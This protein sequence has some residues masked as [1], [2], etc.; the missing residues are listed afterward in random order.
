MGARNTKRPKR[1]AVIVG[2]VRTPFLRAFGAFTR[3][4]AIALGVAAVRGLLDRFRVPWREIDSLFW[5]GVILPGDA[6]NVGREIVL[7]LGLP[8]S[9][10]AMTVTRACTSSLLSVTLAAAAIERGDAEVIIAGGGDSTSNAEVKMPQSL[11]HKMAPVVMS[12]KSTVVDYFKLLA[13]INPARDLVPRQPSVRERTTGEL[14]GEAAERM[15]ARWGISREAQDAFAVQSHMRAAKAYA[16]GILPAE[17]VPVEAPGGRRILRDD[18]VRGDTSVEK[19]SRLRPAF[20]RDGTL[21]AGNSS[22]LTDGAA[23]LLLMSEEK[24]RALGFR[25]LAAFRSWFYSAV[26]PADQLLIGPA[27]AMPEAV[28]RAGMTLEDVDLIDIHEAFA[29]QVLCVLKAM[30]SDRFCREWAGM[31]RA[32]GAIRPE[33][34]NVHGGSVAL[35][36]PFAATGGRMLITMANELVRSGRATALLGLCAAGGQAGAAVLEA[37]A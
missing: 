8:R 25:P 24:A 6:P 33:D 12:S 4:D 32:F 15:A 2:G 28:R 10:E 36:H 37:V 22:A 20:K 19:L 7:D 13:S 5:G 11:V 34:V 23:A 16:E 18:I 35:G 30:G 14:M 17:I 31:E 3:L 1:R 27:I 9:V 21:T 29:A 26:D